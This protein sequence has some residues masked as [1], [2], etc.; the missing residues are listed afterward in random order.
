MAGTRRVEM[1]RVAIE[2]ASSGRRGMLRVA[3]QAMRLEVERLRA[4][5]EP[6]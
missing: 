6:T 4:S 3:W 1:M 2:G 5:R